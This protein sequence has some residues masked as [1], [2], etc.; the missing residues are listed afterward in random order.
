M[1]Q[2]FL[3]LVLLIVQTACIL[4]LWIGT[5]IAGNRFLLWI[6]EIAHKRKLAALDRY[7]PLT[8]L[9]PAIEQ[10]NTKTCVGVLSILIA[11]KSLGCLLLGIVV[12]FWLPFASLLVPSIVALHNPDDPS[13]MA[14]VRNVAVLQVTSHSLAAAIGFAIVALSIQNQVSILEAAG[15]LWPGMICGIVGSLGFALAAGRSETAMLLRHGI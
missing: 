9:R 10:G 15:S 14:S 6:G 12:V 2:I 3:V 8:L 11:L 7:W 1:Q 5:R 4:M 13:L